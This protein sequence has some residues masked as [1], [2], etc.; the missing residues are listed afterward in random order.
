MDG[1]A[2]TDTISYTPSAADTLTITANVTNVE[3]VT[4]GGTAA[5][6]VDA[7][8]AVN[9]LAITGNGAANTLVGSGFGDT[10][11]G[12]GDG[13][14]LVGGGGNDTIDGGSGTDTASFA[15]NASDYGISISGSTVT[16]TDNNVTD[17]DD[18]TDTVTTV[19]V[20]DFAGG[21]VLIVGAGGFATIQEAVNAAGN[22]DTI[23]IAEGT[24]VEQV[25]I[26][27]K[28]DLTL[29][30]VGEVTIK[31]PADVIETARSSSD[32]EMH[33]VVTIENGTNIKLDNINVD[34]DGRGDTVDEGSGT[35]QAQF[36][37]VFVR[38]ASATLEDV[39]ITGVRDPYAPGTTTGTGDPV[40]SGVQRGVALQV[41]NDTLLG[42]TMTGGSISDFQKNATVFNRADLNVTGVT[43]TGGGDQPIN[44]QNGIQVLNSTGTIANNIITKIGYAGPAVAYSGMI[45][46]F[47]NTDL[48]ITGNTI[49]GT[50]GV[51][52]ASKVVGI[53]ILDFGPDNNGGSITGNVISHVDSGI[54]VSGGLGPNGLVITDNT[55]TNIDTS[56][57]FTG[58]VT[59]N[60]T[61]SAGN[62]VEGSAGD[63]ELTG[64]AAT[65][66]SAALAATTP[67]PAAAARMPLTAVRA[68][69]PSSTHPVLI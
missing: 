23:L 52:T 16:V 14:T 25:Q 62:T 33:S 26:D 5:G 38:N 49:T 53:F 9:G 59:F 32:R 63:D 13:D 44:A 22:G 35:G 46:G 18:G 61:T 1:G 19:E 43:I 57:P 67:S 39:D 55:V 56:D 51:N 45:L 40:V 29:I 12:G 21:N 50:N 65:T 11:V 41:D 10:L 31:A 68:T 34:G 48:D 54:D 69:T 28:S 15:G 8:A 64:G 3:A 30:G 20:L 36:T 17:G 66:T 4:I 37:G 58:G 6:S 27:G 47:G 60:P 24:Y 42:F 7:S 2:D